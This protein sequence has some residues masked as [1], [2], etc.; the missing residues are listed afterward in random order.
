MAEAVEKVEAVAEVADESDSEG[1]G[2]DNDAEP[3][4][5]K[6]GG[7]QRKLER[8]DQELGLK[9]QEI[10]ALKA[11]LGTRDAGENS[12]ERE[13]TPVINGKPTLAQY[14]G[15]LER[16]AEALVDW[17]D[18]AKRR[19][20]VWKTRT[21][22][23]AKEFNDF[24]EYADTQIDLTPQMYEFIVDSEIGPKLGYALAKDKTEAQRIFG[25][26]PVQQMKALAKLELQLTGTPPPPV[27]Q[28]TKASAPP[29]IKPLAGGS[30]TSVVKDPRR[31]DMTFQEH[32]AWRNSGGK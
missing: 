22:D 24:D 6:K 19:A 18:E 11:Q 30:T 5:K 13:S 14:D 3:V 28:L 17:K 26:S 23:A 12:A 15:D 16:W 21:A 27:Q 4:A 10:A 2:G 31:S 29:P 20:E 32:N 1:D 7:F 8:K 9:D 25:L